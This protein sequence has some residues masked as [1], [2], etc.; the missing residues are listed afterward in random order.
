[1]RS[2]L[3]LPVGVF[4]LAGGSSVGA[5][6]A[7]PHEDFERTVVTTARL[8]EWLRQH[9]PDSGLM[10]VSSAAV[11][12]AGHVA[13]IAEDGALN[14]F[15]PY[16]THKLVM[17]ELCRSYAVNDG[18]SV[19]PP[20][21]FS[22]YGPELKKQLLWDLCH[23]LKSGRVV[24]LGGSGEEQ[25]DWTHVGDV[26][27]ALSQLMAEASSDAPVINVAGGISVPVREVAALVAGAWEGDQQPNPVSFSGNSRPG[28]PE[29]LVADVAR[30]EALGVSCPLPL[31]EGIAEYV[32][33]FRAHRGSA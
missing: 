25:R 9:S 30:M 3:G 29:F 21:L 33:W 26:V 13:P 14:P 10:A 28:D 31:A 20:R 2:A 8:L 11:Y 7:G 19:V 12:G 17:E 15:S 22:V 23:K 32:R 6:I 4:H 5:A 1:M 27:S 18:L 24:E 16:G